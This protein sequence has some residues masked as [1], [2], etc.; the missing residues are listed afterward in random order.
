MVESGKLSPRTC[1]IRSKELEKWVSK[2]REQI[3][4]SR[5]DMYNSLASA[6]DTLN[7]TQ[8]DLEFMQRIN[9][10]QNNSEIVPDNEADNQKE[11]AVVRP[12]AQGQPATQPETQ[13]ER[14]K[15]ARAPG[16]IKYIPERRKPKIYFS[17]QED[18]ASDDRP[19]D[20]G[21]FEQLSST[22]KE[23]DA[24]NSHLIQ[25][26]KTDPDQDDQ[27][28]QLNQSSHSNLK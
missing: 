8:R 20:L 18:E 14:V 16:N 4:K 1:E 21:D 13:G 26:N 5:S 28:I 2:E 10:S 15:A 17:T 22:L 11:I 12:E 19:F 9:T 7:R 24:H 23:G 6:T 3:K 27:H 25:C